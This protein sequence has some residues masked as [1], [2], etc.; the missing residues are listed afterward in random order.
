MFLAK[1]KK[2]VITHLNDSKNRATLPAEMRYIKF[3][4]GIQE[5][6]SEFSELYAIKSNRDGVPELSGAVITDA[7][8][9][10]DQLSR[11][12]V[13]MQMNAKGAKTWE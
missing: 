12:A 4:W 8:Q 10:F 6:D 2:K 3:V 11:P 5:N 7:R 9:D 1:D 13:S